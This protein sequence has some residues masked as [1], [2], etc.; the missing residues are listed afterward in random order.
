MKK[1]LVLTIAFIAGY[2]TLFAQSKIFKEV[3]DEISSTM[4]L[5]R[6]DNALV[7]Y[8]VFSKL[9]KT[10]EDSFHY[11]INIMDENLNDLGK[12]DFNDEE[13]AI[14]PVA[15]EQ[16]VLCLTYARSVFPPD[17]KVDR[18]GKKKGNKQLHLVVQFLGLDGKIINTLT[19]KTTSDDYYSD[20]YTMNKFMTSTMLKNITGK[21]FALCSSDNKST[22][23][24]VYSLAGTKLWDKEVNKDVENTSLLTTADNIFVFRAINKSA[25][26]GYYEMNSYAA[27]DGKTN[28]SYD[29]RD[30][31]R[32]PYQILKI[33]TDPITGKPY[34]AGYI[35]NKKR[36]AHEKLKD[37]T[38]DMYKGV[39]TLNINGT[40]KQD[41]QQ[42]NSYWDDGSKAEISKK[43]L[44]ENIN[45]YSHFQAAFKDFEG[46]TYYTG[47]S[48]Q[49][50]ARIGS[51]ISTI[52]T[53]P[54]I[55]PP[56]FI[57]PFGYTKMKFSDAM[58][59]KQTP[60]GKLL[61]EN[62]IPGNSSKYYSSRRLDGTYSVNKSFYTVSNPDTKTNFLVMD[63]DD[64]IFVYNVNKKKVVRTIAHK[65]G[66]VRT[67][68]FPAKEG[69]VMV[70][71]YNKK[72]KYTRLSIESL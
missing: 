50:K 55:L 60:D 10:S 8:L 3:G 40:G 31:E 28:D 4:R 33:D 72:E 62:T 19:E 43:G 54:L 21:G 16:D 64:D 18:K 47:S 9:E 23:L 46:N 17:A 61:Y 20:Y 59:V 36:S 53:A 65:E 27:G 44:F 11:R 68:I 14:G 34:M 42:V 49:K 25:V 32:N 48:L 7:G 58:L 6:Q 29:L 5:I 22:Y 13:I 35:L 37:Y 52:V 41:I 38:R 26:T 12:V 66:K 15:F 39:F 24:N 70:M 1:I 57:A 45:A 71:E 56:I 67:N 51:I 2:S 30:G 69:H 63:D